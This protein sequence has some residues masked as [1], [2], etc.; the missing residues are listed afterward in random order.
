MVTNCDHLKSL[1]FS[2]ARPAAF[3]EHGAIMA[4][5]VLNSPR[6]IQTS[7]FVVRAF[8]RL[9]EVLATHKALAG[10]LHELE[11][12]LE[13]HDKD[14]RE[15]VAAIHELA[16]PLREKRGRLI[17]FKAPNVSARK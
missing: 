14:I 2:Y 8:I 13:G 9:R 3:T 1:K 15:L 10:K 11:G 5:S 16:E 12:R 4:A 7:V 6:A 17:G